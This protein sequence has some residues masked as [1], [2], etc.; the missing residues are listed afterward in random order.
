MILNKI[1]ECSAE[2]QFVDKKGIRVVTWSYVKK[3]SIVSTRYSPRK[4]Y[5]E[6]LFYQHTGEPRPGRNAV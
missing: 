5:M 3:S 6:F 1:S 2:N 4:L